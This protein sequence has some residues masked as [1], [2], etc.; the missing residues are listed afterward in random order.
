MKTTL[1]ALVALIILSL[2][3]PFQPVSSQNNRPTADEIRAFLSQHPLITTRGGDVLDVTILGEALVID[4][5]LAVLPNQQYDEDLF[6]QLEYD[7]VEA[8]DVYSYFM[9]TFKVEGFLLEHWGRAAPAFLPNPQI[10]RAPSTTGGE[11]LSGIKIAL[12]PGH[13]LFWSEYWEQWAYQRGEFYGIREDLVNAEIMRYVT[14]ALVNQGATVIDLREM[15]PNARTGV[16]GY[17]AWHESARQYMIAAGVPSWVW[18]SS[19]T[20]YNKDIRTRPY[21]ANYFGADILISLHNNGWNGEKT[22]TETYYDTNNHPGSPA[23]AAAVHNRIINTIRAQYD[24][25]W[26]DRGIKPSDSAYGEINY[27][28]MPAILIELAFMDKQFPDNAYLQDE[29]FK[30]LAAKAIVS[31]ICDFLGVVCNDIPIQLPIVQE[32]PVLAPSY[33]EGVCDSGWLALPNQRG[34]NAY[35]AL[36]VN[37]PADAR[38]LA[39]W[40]PVLPMS[41]VYRVEAFIPNHGALTWDCPGISRTSDTLNARYQVTHSQGTSVVPI[42]LGLAADEWVNLG[43]YY[44]NFGNSGYITLTNATGEPDQ[45]TMVPAS[46]IK[47]TLVGNAMQPIQNTEWLQETDLTHSP[48]T[49]PEQIRNFLAWQH[50]CLVT[51]ITDADGLVM[52]IPSL[53]YQSAINRSINPQILLAIMEKEQNAISQCPD[54]T[55]LANLMGLD[56]PNTA[57][58]QIDNAALQLRLALDTLESTGATPS[59]WRTGLLN[60]TLDNV[61]IIPANDTITTLLE[62]EPLAGASWGGNLPAESGLQGIYSAW[63]SFKFYHPLPTSAPIDYYLPIFFNQAPNL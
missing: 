57:R 60:L 2:V 21:A 9:I 46:A 27:A 35:L 62:F 42:D 26:F 44:F 36:N 40:Q 12:S 28:L 47:F 4:L 3:I 43:E 45:S 53:I 37:D 17:P 24:P 25:N 22:G 38:N 54:Q 1:K 58:Q 29:A 55:A 41:G 7:L 32:T 13:G 11:P 56:P 34:Q 10:T 6:T 8:F 19:N 63:E 18:N 33:G 23:L 15:D 16:T 51:P 61:E 5:S 49:P 39:L 48:T 30:Q 59:G 52:D 14:A 20:N 50:S 31:G